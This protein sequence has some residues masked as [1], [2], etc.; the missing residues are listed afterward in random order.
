L[1]ATEEAIK[2]DPENPK[3]KEKKETL[4]KQ[5]KKDEVEKEEEENEKKEE[6][7]KEEVKKQDVSAQENVKA[8]YEKELDDVEA[9]VKS[10]VNPPAA[11]SGEAEK[12]NPDKE[13]AKKLEKFNKIVAEDKAREEAEEEAK[14]KAKA[15]IQ[16]N[17]AVVRTKQLEEQH[18]AEKD[19]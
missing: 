4:H 8:K 10:L 1:K 11:A 6:V 7:V 9:H 2:K 3:L 19:A 5:V 16:P 14:E 13:K 17:P 15:A 18:Q 12:E